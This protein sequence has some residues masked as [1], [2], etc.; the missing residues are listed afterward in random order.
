M[1]RL[2]PFFVVLLAGV[3]AGAPALAQDTDAIVQAILEDGFYV[4]SDY[5][6]SGLS[7][8][9]DEAAADAPFLVALNDNISDPS[10]LAPASG[11]GA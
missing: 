3:Y 10:A 4:E 2:M 1:Q 8:A 7:E 5:S 9:M 11:S 6:Q